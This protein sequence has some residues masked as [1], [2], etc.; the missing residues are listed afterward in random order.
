MTI[1]HT[2]P[3]SP[4]HPRSRINLCF[5][6]PGVRAAHHW[7][8]MMFAMPTS[9]VVRRVRISDI[10]LHCAEFGDG[11]PVLFVHGFPI[12]GEMW[13]D[14]AA[15]LADS[16][17]CIVPDLRG[18]GRSDV[19][20]IVSMSRFADDLSELLGALGETRPVALVGLSMG[21]IISFEFFRRHRAK[22][23]A[24]GL[25]CTRANDETSEGAARRHALADAVLRHG[26]RF[27][28]DAMIDG[29]FAPLAPAALKARW[30]PVMESCPPV[31]VAAAARALA[32]R[33]ESF[34]TLPQ[35]DVPTLVVAGRDD[36][37]TAPAGLEEMHRAIPRSQYVCID[38][39]GHVPPIEQPALF[40]AALRAFLDTAAPLHPR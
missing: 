18:L 22:L 6:R 4:V 24:L 9:P 8:C 32:T 12:T 28:V 26:S 17:R 37:L 27:A 5:S 20:E 14:T 23:C 33:R 13:Y 31:G 19:C 40:T 1:R 35:I 38:N 30:R 21:G 16:Y 15:Q 3:Q 36:T 25:V 2:P 29:I 34:S 11:P 10:S 7:I 39:S